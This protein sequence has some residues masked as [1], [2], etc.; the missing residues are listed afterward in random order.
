MSHAARLSAI[1]L[2]FC[3]VISARGADRPPLERGT[4]IIDPL[5]L[6]EL[7]RGRFGLMRIMQPAR[8]ADTPLS[9]AQL[10][11]LPSM[12]PVKKALDAEFERYIAKHKAEMPNESIGVG[13]EF[14]FQLFDRAQLYSSDTRFVLS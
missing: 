3:C 5:A 1:I 10:F 14:A 7:D 12:V 8:S 13:S 2:I 6:R 9:N 4:A 11:A